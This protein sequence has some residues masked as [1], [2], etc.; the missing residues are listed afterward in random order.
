[1][2]EPIPPPGFPPPPP[3]VDRP[4]AT[5][6][7]YEAVPV[8][9]IAV[10]ASTIAAIVAGGAGSGEAGLIAGSAAFEAALALTVVLWIRAMHRPALPALGLPER[11]WREVARGLAGGIGT[12]L[13]AAFGIAPVVLLLTDAFTERPPV[14]PEQVPTN[15]DVVPQ[16]LLGLVVV[17][18]APIGEEL[19]FR[20]FLFR[21]LRRRGFWLAALVSSAAFGVVH[22]VD[23]NWLLVPIMMG[24]GL[25]FAGLYERDGRIL[26]PITAHATF[27][28][29][30]ILFLTL[31]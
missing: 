2:S 5:W 30:G 13:V 4:V 21:S 14:V 24:V 22:V 16:V 20:G 26:T 29:I 17:V 8:F 15:L 11:P 18:A 6:R 25:C 19:F 23:G 31:G 9:V 27:N 3:P 1:M 10:L 12:R 7:V 28:L